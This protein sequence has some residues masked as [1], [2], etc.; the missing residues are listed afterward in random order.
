M[1]E[2]EPF[3]LD[4]VQA[5][6]LAKQLY[7]F[8]KKF[9]RDPKPDEPIFF[10]PDADQPCPYPEHK[11]QQQADAAMMA[12]RLPLPDQYARFKTGL[13]I[14]PDNR[15]RFTPAQINAWDDAQEEYELLEQWAACN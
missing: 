11:L 15:D 8:R 6:L 10:D 3:T 12:M 5:K 2:E 7:A 1:P 14:T 4:L 13:L 9:G